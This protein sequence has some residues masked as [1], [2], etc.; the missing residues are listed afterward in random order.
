[1]NTNR[2]PE[3]FCPITSSHKKTFLHRIAPAARD[4]YEWLISRA[5]AGQFQEFDKED[6][7]REYLKLGYKPLSRGWFAH[8]VKLLVTR[9][10]LIIHRTF[11]RYGF[12]ATVIHPWQLN[13]PNRTSKN[14][15]DSERVVHDS[16]RNA[17]DSDQKS[18]CDPHSSVPSYR[19][20]IEK[21]SNWCSTIPQ[22]T[23]SCSTET[24]KDIAERIAAFE[25][26]LLLKEEDLLNSEKPVEGTKT[27][28]PEYTEATDKARAVSANV[29]DSNKRVN[30]PPP[31]KRVEKKAKP[32]LNKEQEELLDEADQHGIEINETILEAVKRYSIQ[33]VKAAIAQLRQ[34]QRQGCVLNRNGYFM[35]ALKENWAGEKAN[36]SLS[37]LDDPKDIEARFGYWYEMARDFGDCTRREDRDGGIWVLMGGTWMRWLDAIEKGFSFEYY[38][39]RKRQKK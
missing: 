34:R 37:D 31:P 11:H 5:K 36:K 19:V 22:P 20:S 35:Q 26:N 4:L 21:Q 13:E 27:P 23:P 32:K 18:T 9:G 7:D 6:F 2:I 33:R 15:H 25:K 39:K 16:E 14:V 30:V 38:Q 10:C 29:T 24:A 28:E 8:I 12:K 1:M 3:A 17:H